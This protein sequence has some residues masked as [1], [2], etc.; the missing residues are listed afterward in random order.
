[1]ND[2]LLV[3]D[4]SSTESEEKNIQSLEIMPLEFDDEN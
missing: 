4:A 2:K 1:M 3:K